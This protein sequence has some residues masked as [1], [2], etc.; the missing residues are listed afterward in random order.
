MVM[1]VG[2]SGNEAVAF[3]CKQSRVDVVA[4]Y[5]ITPQTIVVERFSEYVANGEVHTEFINVE[6]EH[7][8]M[9]ACIGASLA[10]ARV[11][12]A[13]CSQ[14]LALMHELLY[15]ASALRCPIVMM[16]S[17]RALSAPINIHGDHSD[18]MGS[19]DCG[20]IQIFT[21]NPQEAYDATIQAFKIAEDKEVL[22]PVTI[23]LDG[24]ITSH[25][26]E[27]VE[28]LEDFD[29]QN[30]LK[31]RSPLYTLNP[32]KPMTFGP[33]CLPDFYF[34]F[35]RQQEDAMGRAL[36]KIKEVF[37]AYESISGRG[38]EP[39]KA[40][41]LKDAEVALVCMGS[42]SGTVKV[43][44]DRMR[45]RGVKAG[46]LKIMV[47]RPFPVEEVVEALRNVKALA[48][49]DRALSPGAVGGPLF[50]DVAAALYRLKERPLL[51]NIVYGLGGRDLTPANIEEIVNKVLEISK[52]GVVKEYIHFVGVRE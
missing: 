28:A 11:F 24:F 8:A 7:S 9:S 46:L 18:S 44:I 40:Y 21:E 10:G 52:T 25:C 3:A 45:S 15:I 51:Q 16:V 29:V 30:F 33:L 5:P 43:V 47:Y 19:R 41:R 37:K 48:I 2:L 42:A 50:T 17:N 14:G 26:V 36:P 39:L 38:Y 49:L 31:T 13:T 20:W 22:L 34:E 1:V 32:D 6:S 35:K 4:A 12:T 27:R 23:N